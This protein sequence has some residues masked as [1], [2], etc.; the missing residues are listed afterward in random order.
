MQHTHHKA[1]LRRLLLAHRDGLSPSE[2]AEHSSRIVLRMLA[3]DPVRHAGEVLLYAAHR[4]EVST[5]AL[6][7][8]YWQTG[9]RVLLPRCAP[10]DGP[11][12]LDIYCVTCH[13]DLMEGFA[14]IPEPDPRACELVEAFAPDVVVVPGVAFS[15]DGARIGFGGGY[16]DRLLAELRRQDTPPLAVA[17]A[18]DFQVVEHFDTEPHDQPVDVIVTEERTIRP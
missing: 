8:H 1:E 14:S 10:D 13:E 7:E 17:P 9:A 18:Y 6:L 15:P 4:G 12:A 2:V 5:N 16:Y 11:G 3:I